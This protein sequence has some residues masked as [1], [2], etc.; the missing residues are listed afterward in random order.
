MRNSQL[1]NPRSAN[2]QRAFGSLSRRKLLFGIGVL[3]VSAAV[4]GL[5]VLSPVLLAA[6]EGLTTADWSRLS[7]I[8]QTYG[9]ASAI[10]RQLL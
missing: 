7:E 6:L 2:Y 5:I 9:A 8:G 10:W 3:V 1:P 4:L